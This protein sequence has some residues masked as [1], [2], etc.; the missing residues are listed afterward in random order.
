MMDYFNMPNKSWQEGKGLHVDDVADTANYT[1][2]WAKKIKGTLRKDN[3]RAK[4]S[5]WLLNDHALQYFGA[6][7]GKAADKKKYLELFFGKLTHRMAEMPT[8]PEIESQKR[9]KAK[10]AGSLSPEDAAKL[11]DLPP[12]MAKVMAKSFSG[13]EEDIEHLKPGGMLLR[14][15]NLAEGHI[16]NFKDLFQMRQV[17]HMPSVRSAQ[18][19]NVGGFLPWWYENPAPLIE[20]NLTAD[21]G[22]TNTTMD[23]WEKAGTHAEK[24]FKK[25]KPKQS[26]AQNPARVTTEE[27]TYQAH[28]TGRQV[29]HGPGLKRTAPD[30][31]GRRPLH[32][33][34]KERGDQIRQ[35][36]GESVYGG[37]EVLRRVAEFEQG[38][39]QARALGLDG[40]KEMEQYL[41]SAKLTEGKIKT[42]DG[43]TGYRALPPQFSPQNLKDAILAGD[44][45]PEWH[46]NIAEW[47]LG[48]MER[49]HKQII[50]HHKDNDM[51]LPEGFDEENLKGPNLGQFYLSFA[52]MGMKFGS[53]SSAL[54]RDASW[55]YEDFEELSRGYQ[56]YAQA[57]VLPEKGVEKTDS[58]YG[59]TTHYDK[60]G[61]VEKPLQAVLSAQRDEEGSMRGKIIEKLNLIR[62]R[63]KLEGLV[64]PTGLESLKIFQNM[65][66]KERKG[67]PNYK[68][69]EKATLEFLHMFEKRDELQGFRI[70]KDKLDDARPSD[71]FKEVLKSNQGGGVMGQ[72]PFANILNSQ[73][74]KLSVNDGA[75]NKARAKENSG[76][77]TL[78]NGQWRLGEGVLV[79]DDGKTY[80][81]E[82]GQHDKRSSSYSQFPENSDRVRALNVPVEMLDKIKVPHREERPGVAGRGGHLPAPINFNRTLPEIFA[83][84]RYPESVKGV[85]EK[86]ELFIDKPLPHLARPDEFTEWRKQPRGGGLAYSGEVA[87]AALESNKEFKARDEDMSDKGENYTG[88][89]KRSGNR[90]FDIFGN[91]KNYKTSNLPVVSILRE[92]DGGFDAKVKA[93]REQEFKKLTPAPAMMPGGKKQRANNPET[94][95]PFGPKDFEPGL[96]QRA[97]GAVIRDMF[98]EGFIPS[99]GK[100]KFLQQTGK[101]KGD[102]SGLVG[103]DEFTIETM[104]QEGELAGSLDF[105]DAKDE[106]LINYNESYQKGA[107]FAGFQELVRI[108]KAKGKNIYSDSIT[109]Q[110]SGENADEILTKYKSNW[111]A[112]TGK[113]AFPQLRHR[114]L[115]GITT[116]GEYSHENVFDNDSMNLSF[117]SL[118]ELRGVV[119]SESREAYSKLLDNEQRG[120]QVGIN[121]LLTSPVRGTGDGGIPNFMGPGVGS[122]TDSAK[123]EG[124]FGPSKWREVADLKQIL[125]W[126]E[127]KASRVDLQR[128]GRISLAQRP[129]KVGG[130]GA[131]A[132][133]GSAPL[134]GGAKG[135]T[136]VADEDDKFKIGLQF[137]E[138]ELRKRELEAKGHTWE[139]FE[140]HA[141]AD[142]GFS[143]TGEIS[144]WFPVDGIGMDSKL[145]GEAK[146]HHQ[147]GKSASTNPSTLASKMIAASLSMGLWPPTPS[148]NDTAE[149]LDLG[150]LQVAGPGGSYALSKGFIPNYLSAKGRET[151][152]YDLDG[153]I[154]KEGFFDWNDPNKVSEISTSDLT[155]LGQKL[156]QSKELVDIATARDRKNAA[157][158]KPALSGVGINVGKV[159][160]LSSMFTSQKKK[161]VRKPLVNLTGPDKKRLI[162]DKL[163]RDLIDND[164]KNIDALGPRGIHYQGQA[165]GH[166]PNYLTGLYDSD[167]LPK[168]V[169]RNPIID[170]IIAEAN[171]GKKM[172]VFH[173]PAGAGKTKAAMSRYP[174]AELLKDL[175]QVAQMDD[176][177]VVS[178]TTRSKKS[179]EYS[180]RAQNILNA[181]SKITAVVPT[182]EDLTKRRIKRVEEGSTEDDR[183]DKGQLAR[184]LKAPGPDY[185]LYSDLKKSGSNLE[186]LRGGGHIPSF[187]KYQM[188]QKLP[189]G[190]GAGGRHLAVR[191]QNMGIHWDPKAMFHADVVKRSKLE[192]KTMDGGWLFPDGRYEKIQGH[193]GSGLQSR[194][195]IPNFAQPFTTKKTDWKKEKRKDYKGEEY[196]IEAGGEIRTT[197]GALTYNETDKLEIKYNKSN[198]RGGGFSQFKGLVEE[199]ERKGK[200]IFS[201]T[202]VNQL[203]NQEHKQEELSKLKPFEQL[204][205]HAFPQLRQRMLEGLK[206]RGS[207]SWYIG[208]FLGMLPEDD[209][210]HGKFKRRPK[211]PRFK[212]LKELKGKANKENPAEFAKA[213]TLGNVGVDGLTT[214]TGNKAGM[215]GKMLGR[216]GDD[217]NLLSAGLIP[218]FANPLS[219]AVSREAS[220]VPKSKIRVGQDNSLKSSGNP[221]GLGVYNTIHEPRG[222]KQGIQR[223]RSEKRNPKT[224]GASRGILPNFADEGVTI[225][226]GKEV[227]LEGIGEDDRA[228]LIDSINEVRHA[229]QIEA[230]NSEEVAQEKIELARKAGVSGDKLRLYSDA[231]TK[232]AQS[233]EKFAKEQNT[234][235]SKLK[236]GFAKFTKGFTESDASD[237]WEG[238]MLSLSIAIPQVTETIKKFGGEGNKSFNALTDSV[239]DGVSMF[240]GITAMFPGP[241]GKAVAGIVAIGGAAKSLAKD[242]Q[243]QSKEMAQAAEKTKEKFTVLQNS[244]T[245][246]AQTFS[247]FEQASADPNSTGEVLLNLQNKL[248]DFMNTIPAEF[249]LEIG[250]VANAADLESKI[251]EIIKKQS[252][253]Q[254]QAEIGVS[255]QTGIDEVEGVLTGLVDVLGGQSRNL[256]QIFQGSTGELKL[257]RLVNDMRKGIDFRGLGREVSTTA[258]MH[259]LMNME[260]NKFISMLGEQ[261]DASAQLQLVLRDLSN[262]DLKKFKESLLESAR[263]AERQAAA[264]TEMETFKEEK[265]DDLGMADIRDSMEAFKSNLAREVEGMKNF[266]GGFAGFMDPKGVVG[267]INEALRNA[268]S[269]LTIAPQ[270]AQGDVQRARGSMGIM[271]S[272]MDFGTFIPGLETS[273]GAGMGK[274]DTDTQSFFDE[275]NDA[276]ETQFQAMMTKR[277]QMMDSER[278]TLASQGKDTSVVDSAIQ[279]ALKS[280]GRTGTATEVE[281]AANFRKRSR[282]QQFEEKIGLSEIKPSQFRIGLST[283]AAPGSG[284]AQGDTL[285]QGLEAKGIDG[286]RQQAVI[287]SQ[288]ADKIQHEMNEYDEA[289]AN[290]QAE[291]A[292]SPTKQGK[293]AAQAKLADLEARKLALGAEKAKFDTRGLQMTMGEMRSMGELGINAFDPDTAGGQFLTGMKQQVS[294]SGEGETAAE[295]ALREQM[296]HLENTEKLL[297]DAVKAQTKVV[298]DRLADE[299]LKKD[300][301]TSQTITGTTGT[302]QAV[303]A[304]AAGESTWNPFA[305]SRLD[306]DK[307]GGARAEMLTEMFKETGRSDVLGGSETADAG[308]WFKEKFTGGRTVRKQAIADAGTA[309][310]QKLFS[311]MSAIMPEIVKLTGAQTGKEL[312]D[313]SGSDLSQAIK[314]FNVEAKAEGRELIAGGEIKD[315]ERFVSAAFETAG[316]KEGKATAS[317]LEKLINLSNQAVKDNKVYNKTGNDYLST[318]SNWDN[319]GTAAVTLHGDKIKLVEN[320]KKQGKI[321]EA[322]YQKMMVPLNKQS[323]ILANIRA[324]GGGDM[325]T[326]AQEAAFAKAGGESTA[327]LR[328]QGF[329]GVGTLDTGIGREAVDAAGGLGLAAGTGAT[330]FVGGKLAARANRGAWNAADATR[331]TFR[332]MSSGGGFGIG[333]GGIGER[334]VFGQQF[335]NVEEG[336][337][338]AQGVLNS[339]KKGRVTVSDDT[340]EFI[341]KLLKEAEDGNEVAKE[342]LRRIGQ[343]AKQGLGGGVTGRGAATHNLG[344][345]SQE[346]GAT[347]KVTNASVVADGVEEGT[348]A[349]NKAATSG[350][351]TSRPATVASGNVGP[352]PGESVRR[353]GATTAKPEGTMAPRRVA[354]A[355]KPTTPPPATDFTRE[356]TNAMKAQ[357]EADAKRQAKIDLDEAQKAQAGADSRLSKAANEA[358]VNARNQASQ[359][360]AN[361]HAGV[362]PRTQIGTN[363][364]PSSLAPHPS[365]MPSYRGGAVTSPMYNRGYFAD[366]ADRARRT[367]GAIGTKVSEGFGMRGS[368]TFNIGRQQHAASFMNQSDDAFKALQG[369]HRVEGALNLRGQDAARNLGKSHSGFGR[370]LSQS[371]DGSDAARGALS[372]S[373]NLSS[374]INKQGAKVPGLSAVGGGAGSSLLSKAGRAAPV[375]GGVL[376]VLV[377]AQGLAASKNIRGMG[378]FEGATSAILNMGSMEKGS[379]LSR[380]AGDNLGIQ[381]MQ[382]G[383]GFESAAGYMTSAFTGAAGGAGTGAMIGGAAGAVGGPLAGATAAGGAA[384]G[385]IVG[386]VGGV[387]SEF[388]KEFKRDDIAFEEFQAAMNFASGNMMLVA[389]NAR[390]VANAANSSGL[391]ASMENAQGAVDDFNK[392]R[393]FAG[394]VNEIG[395]VTSQFNAVGAGYSEFDKAEK[396]TGAVGAFFGVNTE[397]QA[398]EASE[399]K[400]SMQNSYQ[401]LIADALKV[402]PEKL[403]RGDKLSVAEQ[404]IKEKL[405]LT[406]AGQSG[407]AHQLKATPEEIAGIKKD[408]SEP[409]DVAQQVERIETNKRLKAAESAA[410]H[411]SGATVLRSMH[412]TGD[413]DDLSLGASLRSYGV[414]RGRGSKSLL[415]EQLGTSKQAKQ[416]LGGKLSGEETQAAFNDIINEKNSQGATES[417]RGLIMKM[418]NQAQTGRGLQEKFSKGQI[419]QD[420][421]QFG[422]GSGANIEEVAKIQAARESYRAAQSGDDPLREF[423]MS[424]ALAK[425]SKIRGDVGLRQQAGVGK[426]LAASGLTGI[427]AT[428]QKEF[429]E[430]DKYNQTRQSAL[431]DLS[432]MALE[433]KKM[434]DKRVADGGRGEAAGDFAAFVKEKEGGAVGDLKRKAKG[435]LGFDGR[436]IVERSG[437]SGGLSNFGYSTDARETIAQSQL[438]PEFA[439]TEKSRAM[440]AKS[441]E[442]QKRYAAAA[443]AAGIST[444]D[445]ILAAKQKLSSSRD[446]QDLKYMKGNVAHEQGQVDFGKSADA[447]M[448]GLNAI[449]G[450]K[451]DASGK[452][453]GRAD[454]EPGE[455]KSPEEMRAQFIAN[456]EKR[457]DAAQ[458]KLSGAQG[459]IAGEGQKIAKMSATNRMAKTHG[460]EFTARAGKIASGHQKGL[461]LLDQMGGIG[462]KEGMASKREELLAQAKGLESELEGGNLS[463]EEQLTKRNQISNLQKTASALGPI[464]PSLQG[465]R[466]SH[467]ERAQRETVAAINQQAVAGSVGTGQGLEYM[468]LRQQ[469]G[470]MLSDQR[471]AMAGTNQAGQKVGLSAFDQA[472]AAQQKRDDVRYDPRTLDKKKQAATVSSAIESTQGEG[473]SQNFEKRRQMLIEFEN[474]RRAG[475]KLNM[476]PEVAGQMRQVQGAKMK[477]F[478]ADPKF[479]EAIRVAIVEG[480]KQGQQEVTSKTAQGEETKTMIRGQNADGTPFEQEVGAPAKPKEVAEAQKIEQKTDLNVQV[481]EVKVTHAGSINTPLVGREKA[482]VSALG[483]AIVI[484]KG[485][486]DKLAA[487]LNKRL[488]APKTA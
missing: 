444:D 329:A 92:M 91:T 98:A 94:G 116:R 132:R 280:S 236:A 173:G 31:I 25:V 291:V 65:S 381:S 470:A 273:A 353:V 446:V 175:N 143:E 201:G 41:A 3:S 300:K 478:Q 230:V 233:G 325:G 264:V 466:K 153:T 452:I 9:G 222:L 350:P 232:A 377:G 181:A 378:G 162:A 390:S 267:P 253:L 289:I 183:R 338:V 195:L 99:F 165:G 364:Q 69:A 334:G 55:I 449:Y 144:K 372:Q 180:A 311:Q 473:E 418:V 347:T 237:K 26:D 5:S 485:D 244:L 8:D 396:G 18:I 68:Q 448:F 35:G 456:A 296:Q 432:N 342:T 125:S 167:R 110:L 88:K 481:A 402:I 391:F 265:A 428:E 171:A 437:I 408:F 177:A 187:L 6:G 476:T 100:K 74:T 152:L 128:G 37:F 216:R 131:A 79:G 285:Q 27:G 147:I 447:G 487:E 138:H 238:R 60:E 248:N 123:T 369:G 160:P 370:L 319:P 472:R 344:V 463:R 286:T 58:R 349:A 458:A 394:L 133:F 163:G 11:A 297:T 211:N 192:G 382:K 247:E 221:S 330:A 261:F 250:S 435:A 62:E 87:K 480:M 293:A 258:K 207:S 228:K 235:S 275:Y 53:D 411:V 301:D 227:G 86:K 305:T 308:R 256:K 137:I 397:E 385:A 453:L 141:M 206:T 438:N 42:K 388:A 101:K 246:Y 51:P 49:N 348:K 272:Q 339:S 468:Q 331:S 190:R 38:K 16:P 426:Q 483:E 96:T 151:P 251:A 268:L 202:L 288:Y 81:D 317:N 30:A 371:A 76:L 326:A 341:K 223:A 127:V 114:L 213:L 361:R 155:N 115:D 217:T 431:T 471:I 304:E 13:G 157:S 340:A 14:G 362:T 154:I 277:I 409:E 214:S 335:N 358:R 134:T 136:D 314:N 145:M 161:G 80:L 1:W 218:S 205:K 78:G 419:E 105:M 242:L 398:D 46:G 422:T 243:N 366:L 193:D 365:G 276:A 158:I 363:W 135:T 209:P 89:R 129:D 266:A 66:E 52:K 395:D 111:G 200:E 212:S 403:A 287:V 486:G 263:A 434:V 459:R 185:R 239:S 164:Q 281:E 184:T 197:A 279:R 224:Y 19:E 109:R 430:A 108:A 176:Y 393:A 107:G 307:F 299:M 405:N 36:E 337:R 72:N 203:Q 104:G 429:S 284:Q 400:K 355:P 56:P 148:K 120:M 322:Q 450:Q 59:M 178:G 359:G 168:G 262:N 241:S 441:K 121:S 12:S 433:F 443:Q 376:D 328:S 22:S 367:T 159:M 126:A 34:V 220:A 421:V 410:G 188:G 210:N 360:F 2:P 467:A 142:L 48:H 415:Q 479:N 67:L 225:D 7:G 436:G 336:K 149:E 4:S 50:K 445:Q 482:V 57:S 442:G 198:Q 260:G 298:Q 71:P 170:A 406:S 29:P 313:V 424:Q 282:K 15:K 85:G 290:A 194:G 186:V 219:D 404:N 122:G 102:G 345:I 169:N 229:Y 380:F 140:K 383:G 130:V 439:G 39:V 47:L 234:S 113:G 17:K 368:Q 252:Q 384:I 75:W 215:L 283:G 333:G 488:G 255:I 292:A 321:T 150:T 379:K 84:N 451:T 174:S 45:S 83:I 240:T 182:H 460:V 172:H 469:Q 204:T 23:L 387:A 373:G 196:D 462:S 64:M 93:L 226:V 310:T 278:A 119:N 166:I 414:Q 407:L 465:G 475:K 259:S 106:M 20:R 73:I 33:S 357:A 309:D 454:G 118:R 427:S 63:A 324:A 346:M 117:R 455:L 10:R 189:K 70:Y 24:G 399:L 352:A 294:V 484:A 332:G 351:A 231:I 77:E 44:N 354:G 386:A 401:Q 412:G 477:Q 269:A 417:E 146:F 191:D 464:D 440:A 21:L 270:G 327:I 323:Q 95:K 257:E 32:P 343:Q 474:R 139:S 416:I 316:T 43:T 374:W 208:D 356:P 112:L 302:A 457:R 90:F 413:K 306:E 156:A 425:E 249:A 271:Q 82:F 312:A 423:H 54:M 124:V 103:D 320:L 28:N 315:L 274:F 245:G 40:V 199:A 179:G 254:I 303:V 318:V 392:T 61:N 389:D 420:L 97:Q 375:A 295:R 461:G